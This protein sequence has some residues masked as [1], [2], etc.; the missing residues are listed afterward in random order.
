VKESRL[1]SD[2]NYAEEMRLENNLHFR[3]YGS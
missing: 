1:K 2:I 3:V